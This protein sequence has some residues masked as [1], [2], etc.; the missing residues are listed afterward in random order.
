MYTS[1]TNLGPGVEGLWLDFKRHIRD[2]GWG[3]GGSFT[4]IGTG[5]LELAGINT[6][7]GDTNVNGGILQI[8][9]SIASNTFVNDDGTLAG[10]GAVNGA[11]T[12]ND[13]GTISPGDALGEPGVLTIGS[14]YTQ[15]PS[16]VL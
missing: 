6:Y 13:G 12:N 15:T 2:S 16:A 10:S 7:T 14:N 5:T 9:G 1:S 8:D 4:K 11:V 3:G